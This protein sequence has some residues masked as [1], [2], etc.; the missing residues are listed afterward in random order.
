M[1]KILFWAEINSVR[2]ETERNDIS[3][4]FE[5][6]DNAEDTMSDYYDRELNLWVERLKRDEDDLGNYGWRRISG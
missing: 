3:D 6:E 4:M 1:K 2:V 5:D